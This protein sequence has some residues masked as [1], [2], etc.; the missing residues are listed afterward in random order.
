MPIELIPC[1]IC[2]ELIS[3]DDYS[4]HIRACNNPIET[5]ITLSIN[6]IRDNRNNRNN[7]NNR[8][9]INNNI[10]N[11]SDITSINSDQ[12][13]INDNINLNNRNITNSLSNI[14]AN[15]NINN[16][17]INSFL[18]II[19]NV[20][21]DVDDINPLSEYVSENEDDSSL[22]DT[23]DES[24]TNDENSEQYEFNN[25]ESNEDSSIYDLSSDENDFEYNNEP[26]SNNR[27]V[28]L[29]NELSF[30]ELQESI[31]EL[32]SNNQQITRYTTLLTNQNN[33]VFSNNNDSYESL[34]NLGERIGVV[35]VGISD[36]NKYSI[37]IKND[38]NIECII[39]R[40]EEKDTMLQFN[41]SH[42]FCK[43]CCNKWFANNKVCPICKK[44]FTTP[45]QSPLSPTS[46]SSQKYEIQSI[47]SQHQIN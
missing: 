29:Y 23:S 19:N 9:N 12:N 7:R 15:P 44:E 34:T 5:L 36:L 3:F 2:D 11:N 46:T 8:H 32:I 47:E 6:N 20:Q 38:T 33:P 35:S 28:P 25:N 26:Y 37:E 17:L 30:I 13:Q 39:C 10:V 45:P 14:I 31:N 24:D 42:I 27:D 21:Q 4:D 16:N 40:E 41:C 1:E 18:N 43:D 22:N